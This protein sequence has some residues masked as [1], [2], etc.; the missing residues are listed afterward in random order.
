MK[1][2]NRF[3]TFAQPDGF[4]PS[5]NLSIISMRSVQMQT[6]VIN[7]RFVSEPKINLLHVVCYQLHCGVRD[8]SPTLR[9]MYARFAHNSFSCCSHKLQ[10]FQ[11]K[12]SRCASSVG[13]ANAAS[14]RISGPSRGMPGG[15]RQ[16][17]FLKESAEPWVSALP[18]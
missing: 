6:L 2:I 12:Y 13:Q 9:C 5:L 16:G 18:Y 1:A 14:D 8:V 10:Y 15:V 4:L 7:F 11:Y 17:H 3:L